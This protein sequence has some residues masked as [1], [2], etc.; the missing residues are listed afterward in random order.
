VTAPLL[1]VSYSR[2]MPTGQMGVL[3]RCLR[4]IAHLREDFE[5][6]LVNYGPLPDDDPTFA[7]VRDHVQVHRLP[8]RALGDELTD[9]SRALRP[10]AF[11]LGEAPLRGNMRTS[12]RVGAHLGFW[13]VAIDNEYAPGVVR[14]LVRSFPKVDRWLTIG[15][16]ER[17]SAIGRDG[18][19]EVVP[20]LVGHVRVGA[21][22]ARDR[23][24]VIGY[25]RQTLVSGLLVARRLSPPVGVDVITLADWMDLVEP[26]DGLDVDVLVWPTDAVLYGTLAR[27]RVVFAKAGFQQIVESILLGARVVCRRAGGGVVSAL[28]PDHLHPFVR[29]MHDD[30]ELDA[31]EAAV[32]SWWPEPTVDRWLPWLDDHRDAAAYAAGR[33]RVLIDE[34]RTSASDGGAGSTGTG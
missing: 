12:H 32:R 23:F 26:T 18:P 17:R 9:L 15:L 13:Q 8:E 31:V 6:H 7:S 21:G 24:C 11:V 10:C 28:L 33:L 2:T 16:P 4:L 22:A 19:R 3:K 34:G 27:A 5:I 1:F 25:D 30:G 14:H 29:W 20:P